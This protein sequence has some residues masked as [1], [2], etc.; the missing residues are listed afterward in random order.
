MN[1]EPVDIRN[2]VFQQKKMRGIDESE[3]RAYLDLIAD[4][5]EAAV[6]EADD[7]RGTI[8]HLERE[9]GE[10]RQLEKALRDSLLSA[11]RITEER[12]SLADKEARIVLKNAEVD[13]EKIVLGSRQETARLRA[14]LDDLR[15]QR[16]TYI[17]RFR[18][19]LRSQEKILEASVES[20]D[21]E[22]ASMDA[23]RGVAETASTILGST[24]PPMVSTPA[25]PPLDPTSASPPPWSAKPTGKPTEPAGSYLGEEGLFASGSGGRTETPEDSPERT[26]D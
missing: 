6:L 21:P 20:F 22:S 13:A 15:R 12:L 2:H 23:A 8:D 24:A 1:I 11:E 16:V 9:I 18:A 10:Y 17:E 19:L 7:L 26:G 5:L 14:D 4:R 3:I 25:P